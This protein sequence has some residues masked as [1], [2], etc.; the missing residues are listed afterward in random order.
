MDSVEVDRFQME[1]LISAHKHHA[2][3]PAALTMCTATPS[4]LKLVR[5]RL[6]KMHVKV[7]LQ[8]LQLLI[9]A[10]WLPLDSC[11]TQSHAHK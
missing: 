7:W 2:W 8:H 3:H 9:A 11:T 4:N 10:C 5:L 6:G 1:E